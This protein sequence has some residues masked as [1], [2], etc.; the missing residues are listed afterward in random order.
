[1]VLGFFF[2]ALVSLVIHRSRFSWT[3]SR[4]VT[5]PVMAVNNENQHEPADDYWLRPNLS[6]GLG[7][8]S[9]ASSP[10]PPTPC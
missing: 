5:M 8:R 7:R 4:Q 6:A 9:A 3:P 10:R 1:M 2:M